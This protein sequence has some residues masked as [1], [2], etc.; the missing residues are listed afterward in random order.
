MQRGEIDA[1]FA[2]LDDLRRGGTMTLRA[3]L[4]QGGILGTLG[5]WDEAARLLTP[6]L[7][8]LDQAGE[9]ALRQA[10]LPV[11]LLSA[12][13]YR[14]GIQAI[15]ARARNDFAAVRRHLDAVGMLPV[16][17]PCLQRLRDEL[18]PKL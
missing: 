10:G 17:I 18:R 12:E 4:E 11:R 5:H 13:R 7:P 1:A 6:L 15:L 16:D 9:E 8:V 14:Q 3:A 2:C